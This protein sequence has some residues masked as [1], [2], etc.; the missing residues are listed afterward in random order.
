MVI[1]LV[2]PDSTSQ[3]TDH[4]EQTK[5]PKDTDLATQLYQATIDLR[6]DSGRRDLVPCVLPD[7]TAE[8]CEDPRALRPTVNF[9]T[10]NSRKVRRL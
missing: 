4:T 3:T 9:G 7:E 8:L 5:Q 10:R 2:D 6:D 1:S